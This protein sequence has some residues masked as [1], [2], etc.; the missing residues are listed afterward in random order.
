[1][2]W[3][4][5]KDIAIG[6]RTDTNEDT[7]FKNIC[8]DDRTTELDIFLALMPVSPEKLLSIVRAGAEKANCKLNWNSDHILAALC[9]IFGGAQFKENTDLWALQRK[10][11][12]PSPD[13]GLFFCLAIVLSAYCIV[14]LTVRKI[15]GESCWKSLGLRLNIGFKALT[16]IEEM[17]YAWEQT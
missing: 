16:K 14:G 12:I 3:T 15:V 9:F 11:M 4:R 1:L 17:N 2:T 5:I 6:Q 13:F 8:I 7:V 10:G